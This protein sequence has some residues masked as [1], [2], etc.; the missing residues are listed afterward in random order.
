MSW[1]IFRAKFPVWCKGILHA[2]NRPTDFSAWL[3]VGGPAA[4]KPCELN[5]SSIQTTAW[6]RPCLKEC[7]A[8]VFSI[9]WFLP[10]LLQSVNWE[11][12]LTRNSSGPLEWCWGLGLSVWPVG[13]KGV[14]NVYHLKAAIWRKTTKEGAPGKV[15][16]LGVCAPKENMTTA[17]SSSQRGRA[18]RR[19]GAAC[20]CPVPL[21]DVGPP[22]GVPCYCGGFMG[23]ETPHLSLFSCIA[24]FSKAGWRVPSYCSFCFPSE[25]NYIISNSKL[26][27]VCLVHDHLTEEWQGRSKEKPCVNERIE[28]ENK[29]NTGSTIFFS[30]PCNF[31]FL[32]LK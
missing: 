7:P 21:L 23:G 32:L 24:C 11:T 30:F 31:H 12:H 20:W 9:E 1:L 26:N 29:R 8:V 10:C 6:P 18:E 16:S 22:F 17:A 28:W 14:H 25:A 27:L 4:E 19:Q 13:P 5:K 2:R 3:P 15:I